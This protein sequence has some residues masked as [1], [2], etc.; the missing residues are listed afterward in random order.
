MEFMNLADMK[1][2]L[3]RSKSKIEMLYSQLPQSDKS[4]KIKWKFDVKAASRE[5]ETE[6][7]DITL[8]IKL[9]AVVRQ[10]EEEGQV[11]SI[12]D[13]RAYIRARLPMRWGLY[14][15]D[16]IRDPVTGMMVYFGSTDDQASVWHGRIVV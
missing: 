14:N 9:Q 8:E 12:D 4:K 15:D 3:Y 13:R 1:F 10:L 6:K 5:T 2:Y 11:G 7:G 16:G